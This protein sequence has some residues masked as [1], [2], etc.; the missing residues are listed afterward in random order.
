M[1]KSMTQCMQ[2]PEVAIIGG[3]PAGLMAAEQLAAAGI[4]VD[5]YEA[6]PSCGR[7]FLIAGKGGL[8]LTHAEPYDAFLGRYRERQPDLQPMLDVF[9]P[10][11]VQDWA[12]GLGIETFV[13]SSR[14]V[15]PLEMKA[16]P[17]LRAWL[18]RLQDLDVRFHLRHRWLGWDEQGDLRFDYPDGERRVRPAVTLLA[19]GGASWPRTGST[20]D[21][22]PVLKR[23]GVPVAP[24]RPANG[25]FL[26]VWSDF[27]RERFAGVPLK[28]V[29]LTC[30]GPEGQ[31]FSRRGEFV[32][33][34]TGIQGSLVYAASA[35]LRDQIVQQ[36]QATLNLDLAPDRTLSEL[37][38][39][40]AQP[41][42]S[43]SLAKHLR[44][45]TG[46]HGVKAS[47]LREVLNSAEMQDPERVAQTIKALPLTLTGTTPIAGAISTAGGVPFEALS[48]DL[49]VK[50]HPN[51]Y[52]AGE[53]LDWEAPTGGYLLTACLATGFWAGKAISRSLN[54]AKG[55]P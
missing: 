14:R 50:D 34:E 36:G 37:V 29:L 26:V 22:V 23:A 16:S 41:R 53:M 6:K 52:I 1:I 20:A 43:Q 7:K 28:T 15:F 32:I 33:T 17:L 45:Q 27:F 38:R 18:A 54:A 4:Q 3:G 46:L 24:L 11:S 49:M 25:G 51:L 39:K 10:Q 5:I 40:L 13:G 12:A 2:A 21:W 30:R 48:A 35:L 19:L 8:N 44:R 42:G 55:T 31:P 9:G 47:L